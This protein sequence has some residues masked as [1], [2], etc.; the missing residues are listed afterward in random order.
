[1][2]ASSI[3]YMACAIPLLAFLQTRPP[4]KKQ[5]EEYIQFLIQFPSDSLKPVIELEAQV[6]RDF[7]FLT[8]HAKKNALNILTDLTERSPTFSLRAVE[9]RKEAKSRPAVVNLVI[10][11]TKNSETAWEQIIG[12]PPKNL[13]WPELQNKF[14]DDVTYGF[15]FSESG[16]KYR[17][18]IVDASKTHHQAFIEETAD[19]FSFKSD[20]YNV[21]IK[22]PSDPIQKQLFLKLLLN[23]T[24]SLA[25]CM[26]HR[27]LGNVMLYVRPSNKKLIDRAARYVQE[28]LKEQ[29]G[30]VVSYRDAVLSIYLLKDDHSGEESVVLKAVKYLQS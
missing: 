7:G 19:S 17:S 21:Q 9:N 20:A 14:N 4:I 16:F 11:S 25:M 1:L 15:D 8:Y 26:N 28:I 23:C 30:K 5:I 6:Y 18:K 24:S 29:H 12:R 2:Q 13:N 22:R 3:L 10:E 27:V